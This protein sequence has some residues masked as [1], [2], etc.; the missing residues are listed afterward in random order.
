MVGFS[1]PDV[2]RFM[3]KKVSARGDA[4]G[5]HAHEVVSDMKVR[6]EGVRIKHRLGKNS[7]KLYDKAYSQQGAVLRPEITMNAPGQFRVFRH[8]A[9]QDEGPMQW[10]QLRA[11]VAD[12]QRRAEV[13]QKALDRYCTA[14]ARV[15][16]TTTLQEITAPLEKRV[17]WNGRPVR[18]LH[19]F[20]SGD[21]ELL[22]AIGRG[23]FTI[24][25]LRN[26][27]LQAL[28]YA[29]PAATKQDARRRSAAVSRKLRLLRAHG[30]IRKLPHT[31]RYLVSDNGRLR[32]NAILSAQRTTTQQLTTLAA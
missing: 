28:L 6:S 2:M 25:G 7:I 20:E 9:G 14:L 31:H 11:G 5:R 17:R 29:E 21:L 26:R 16:D 10:R 8:K 13:S 15:D 3:D 32:I 19:P 18:A 22:R 1:S 24:N 12:L 23:E 30:I 4:V 27:D